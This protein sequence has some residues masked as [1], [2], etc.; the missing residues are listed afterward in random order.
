MTHSTYRHRHSAF[1]LVELLVVLAIMAVV[2]SILLPSIRSARESSRGVV[3]A[4]NLRQL[5]TGWVIYAELSNGAIVPG[6]MAKISGTPNLY[7]VGNGY[8]YRPRWYIQMGAEAGYYACAPDQ[9]GYSAGARPSGIESY[10]TDELTAD[11]LAMADALG[12]ER[13]HLVG[14]DWGGQV[15]W[16]VAHTDRTTVSQ[17]M[18]V[19][20]RSVGRM[21][22]R[23]AAEA[24]QG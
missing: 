5:A 21:V 8:Q 3:C 18:R 6:R 2:M 9:R 23:V 19:T 11:V 14:H 16:L 12:R 10:H 4:T 13:F 20:W 24:R 1:S 7:Y 22:E 15:A 17:L